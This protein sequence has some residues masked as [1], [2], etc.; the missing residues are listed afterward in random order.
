LT[1][2]K[3][4]EEALRDS[5][6]ALRRSEAY[7]AESQQL[8]HIGSVA[9]ND[10]SNFYFSDE[11]YRI[12]GFDPRQG[13]PS[14]EAVAQ[15][16]HP[17]DRK[18]VHELGSR[19]RQEK[20]DYKLEYRFILPDGTIKYIENTSHP[21]FAASGELVEVV[22]TIV[23]ATERKRG[24]EEHERLRQL[25]S[26]LAHMNRLSVMGELVA[27][28]AHEITQPIAT[29]RNNARA[30]LNFLGKNPPDLGEVREALGCVVG[31]ADRAGDI[32]DRI[33]DHI[34][35]APPRKNGFDL[36][37]A[38]SEVLGLARSAIDKDEVS[39]RTSLAGGLLAVQGDR[40]QLQQVVL[41]LILNAVEAMGSVEAGTR[42]LSVSTEQNQ[43][44]DFLVAVRDSGPGIDP[45]DR[46]RIFQAFY[47]TKSSG[48]GM[49][50][51]ICRSIIGAHGG[52]L[53]AVEN[54]PRGAVFQFTLPSADRN[55]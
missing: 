35:K 38:I 10:T 36:N 50:L 17:D 45:E 28:L 14:R 49:G 51:S 41:N 13:L 54:E 3:R 26:D 22:S 23:D 1:E 33:R 20:R 27:S 46:E 9:F 48:I 47:T 34:K 18:R 24:Q 19:A 31:D 39:V 11:T 53:W 44:N 4:A 25:E 12:Y 5:K 7:L 52:R 32:I 15:R 37:A 40:V 6:Q 2:R 21:K 55:S 42:V 43:T 30:A 8:G 16:M 29:A